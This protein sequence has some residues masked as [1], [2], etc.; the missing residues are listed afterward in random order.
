MSMLFAKTVLYGVAFVGA[1]QTAAFIG[2]NLPEWVG[3]LMF[4][5][6]IPLLL[7]AAVKVMFKGGN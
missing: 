5:T 7:W 1:Y 2:A 4:V 6:L 3:V